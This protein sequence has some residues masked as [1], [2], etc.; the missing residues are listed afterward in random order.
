MQ[1]I[2][3]TYSDLALIIFFYML[4]WFGISIL[5]KRN[6]VADIAWGIG[7]LVCALYAYLFLGDVYGKSLLVLFLIEVW[8]FRLSLHILIR[9]KGK[10]EDSRYKKWRDDWGKWFIP[11]TFFQV[12][13]LQGGL[14]LIVFLPA[15]VS[16]LYGGK[17]GIFDFIGFF[18]WFVGFIF[19]TVGDY[20]LS[21]FIK[22]PENKGKVLNTGLWKYTRHP[23][24]FGEV[25]MWWGIWI[26][27]I[28]AG[29]AWLTILG[30]AMITFLILF[31]SGIP[32]LEN[33]K[34]GDP[35]FEEYKTHTSIF[36]PL[37][38]RK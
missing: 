16:I 2:L 1:L 5:F 18:V 35:A 17:I 23:N 14:L 37:P 19:E 31:V 8:A 25:T 34:K 28:P 20:Q 3:Q 29:F 27:A 12:F 10:K 6:D 4:F 38:R 11:R 15:I 7:F 24:Y 13:I 36:F 33:R 21:Q 22:N 32:L 9:N 26:I 30:P